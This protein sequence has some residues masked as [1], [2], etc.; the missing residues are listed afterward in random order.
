MRKARGPQIER[1]LDARHAEGIRTGK[2][3]RSGH[4]AVTICVGFDGSDDA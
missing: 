1:F 3:P 2:R 4:E